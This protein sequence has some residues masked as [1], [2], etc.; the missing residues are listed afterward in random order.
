MRIGV[1]A[2]ESRKNLASVRAERAFR[3]TARLARHA[4]RDLSLYDERLAFLQ[5][6]NRSLHLAR[7]FRAK[8]ITSSVPCVLRISPASSHALRA[9]PIPKW[10][11]SRAAG[12]CASG[13]I[14]MVT[15]NSFAC[16]QYRQSRS[17]R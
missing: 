11:L 2:L 14:A 4:H 7:R 10:T 12:E 17:N 9:M 5:L 1:G 15:P 6:E 13:P 16:R 8:A 3:D